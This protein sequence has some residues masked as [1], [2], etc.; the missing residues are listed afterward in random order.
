VHRLPNE[1]VT[2]FSLLYALLLEHVP[3]ISR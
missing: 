3:F 1:T 2:I